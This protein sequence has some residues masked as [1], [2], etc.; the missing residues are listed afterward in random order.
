MA[1]SRAKSPIKSIQRGEFTRLNSGETVI[2]VAAVDVRKSLLSMATRAVYGSGTPL[3][4]LIFTGKI[5]SATQLVFNAPTNIDGVVC[6]ELVE[7]V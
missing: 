3:E 1:V 6:W 7:Y 2:T 5:L 4:A